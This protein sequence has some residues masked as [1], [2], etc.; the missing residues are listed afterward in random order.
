MFTYDKATRVVV[1]SSHVVARLVIVF[2]IGF[3]YKKA[4]NRSYTWDF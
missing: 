2:H 1:G 4:H 3:K